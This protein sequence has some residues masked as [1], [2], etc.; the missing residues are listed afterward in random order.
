M[1]NAQKKF[2]LVETG[3]I[4]QDNSRLLLLNVRIHPNYIS[5]EKRT[6]TFSRAWT[7]VLFRL[8]TRWWCSIMEVLRK[9][10][11]LR[12]GCTWDTPTVCLWLTSGW[13]ACCLPI[14]NRSRTERIEGACL[15]TQVTK[16]RLFLSAWIKC[17]DVCVFSIINSHL[18]TVV[19]L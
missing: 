12:T 3:V 7:M 19:F 11:S 18:Y 13:R 8:K 6:L 9:D 17:S 10:D 2:S 1:Q 16:L 5:D 14:L 15:Q 4:D